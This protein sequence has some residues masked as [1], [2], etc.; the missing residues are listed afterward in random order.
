MT[1]A[2]GKTMRDNQILW[3]HIKLERNGRRL[4]YTY[5]GLNGCC[6]ECNKKVKFWC[7]VKEHLICHQEKIIKKLLD[8]REYAERKD[9]E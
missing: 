4:F 8:Q 7:K 1:E 6:E 3:K 9:N 5:C 2:K